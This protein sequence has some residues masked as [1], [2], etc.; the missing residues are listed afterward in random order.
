MRT[1]SRF[2]TAALDIGFGLRMDQNS[3]KTSLTGLFQP[4]FPAIHR[5]GTGLLTG[6]NVV[7]L[8]QCTHR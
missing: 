8:D 6:R 4:G 1:L 5:N 3:S 7:C 2:H